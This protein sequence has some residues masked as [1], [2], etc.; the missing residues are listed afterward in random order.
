MIVLYSNIAQYYLIFRE[1]KLIIISYED[2]YNKNLNWFMLIHR[3]KRK[4]KKE[5][6]KD[7]GSYRSIAWWLVWGAILIIE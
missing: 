5:R 4:S 3:N 7:E 1:V 2:N 6:G